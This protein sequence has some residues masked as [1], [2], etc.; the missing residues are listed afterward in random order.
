MKLQQWMQAAL[1]LAVIL[2][3]PALAAEPEARDDFLDRNIQRLSAMPGFQCH[4]EQLM[5]YT[6]GG[7]QSYAGELAVL[8]PGQFR[9]QYK[10]PYEQLYIGDG[11]VIWHYEPDLMQAER[12]SDLESVDPVVMRL[13]DGRVP[14]TDIHILNKAKDS[15]AGIHRYQIR[16]GEDEPATWL[17]FFGNGELSY[18]EREDLLGNTNR[19]SLSACSYIAPAANLFSFTPPEGVE[20]LD[21][22]SNHT[23]E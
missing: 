5:L 23:A 22:R 21:M 13:L 19:M 8:K 1:L 11:H 9:W 16:I 4:F 3:L 20:V 2:P 14:L 12:L 18:I 6:D 10:K 17:G 15:Q 7:K